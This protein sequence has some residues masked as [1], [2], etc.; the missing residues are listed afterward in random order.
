MLK[1]KN[2][3]AF[4]FVKTNAR[5]Q[6]RIRFYAIL[7]GSALI[8]CIKYYREQSIRI[9]PTVSREYKVVKYKYPD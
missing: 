6:N 8:A 5:Y 4:I 2:V 1:E 3:F 7:I 9:F